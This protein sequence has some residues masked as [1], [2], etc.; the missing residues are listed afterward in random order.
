[1]DGNL[2]E[3]A[4]RSGSTD[5]PSEEKMGA[6]QSM[7]GDQDESRPLFA[8]EP[9]LA[10]HFPKATIQNGHRLELLPKEDIS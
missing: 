7:Q 2:S 8:R 5:L 1:M 10:S 9:E 3:C 6:V 4:G